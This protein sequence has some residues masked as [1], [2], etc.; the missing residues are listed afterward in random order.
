MKQFLYGLNWLLLITLVLVAL[1]VRPFYGGW[2]LVIGCFFGCMFA[3]GT[4]TWQYDKD[5]NPDKEYK[6]RKQYFNKEY[7]IEFLIRF[8]LLVLN[9]ILSHLFWHT[10]FYV[11]SGFF[12]MWTVS[13][14]AEWLWGK[15]HGYYGSKN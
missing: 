8:V 13:C 5:G 14:A 9:I 15:C 12:F 10:F 6:W 1:F 2:A 3:A 4:V 11:L 7:S